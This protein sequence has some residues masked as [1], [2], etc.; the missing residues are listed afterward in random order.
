MLAEKG[1][2]TCFSTNLAWAKNILEIEISAWL[3]QVHKWKIVEHKSFDYVMHAYAT[4]CAWLLQ[5]HKYIERF[6]AWKLGG[7]KEG[8]F[9]SIDTIGYIT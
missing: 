9:V 4:S 2:H 5:V 8:I 3:L 6:C 7:Y 1:K